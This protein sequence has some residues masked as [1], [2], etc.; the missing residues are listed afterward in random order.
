MTALMSPLQGASPANRPTRWKSTGGRSRSWPEERSLTRSPPTLP[1]HV[2]GLVWAKTL[3]R[4][5]HS[6]SLTGTPV[7]KYGLTFHSVV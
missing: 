7:W 2:D 5:F 1:A 4:I 6:P 3:P